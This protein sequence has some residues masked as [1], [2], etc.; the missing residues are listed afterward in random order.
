[1]M[2]PVDTFRQQAVHR[3]PRAAVHALV[4]QGGIHLAWSQVYKPLT[5]QQR[6]HLSPFLL[7]QD[8][9]TL[10][11]IWAA[12]PTTPKTAGTG[13]AAGAPLLP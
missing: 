10:A 8:P 9:R 12:M 4:E 2:K 1:M 11:V 6:K 7:A 3:R 13:A 5:A